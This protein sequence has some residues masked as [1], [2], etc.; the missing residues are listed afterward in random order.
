M[1]SICSIAF[2]SRQLE[3]RHEQERLDAPE[4]GILESGRRITQALGIHEEHLGTVRGGRLQV[5]DDAIVMAARGRRGKHEADGK[6]E[7]EQAQERRLSC[8]RVL[9][10]DLEPLVEDFPV[11]DLDQAVGLLKISFRPLRCFSG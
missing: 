6:D 10:A 3:E 2:C 7:V 1:V 9:V 8:Q 5:L 11:E 4:I